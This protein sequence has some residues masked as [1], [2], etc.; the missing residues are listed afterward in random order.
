VSLELPHDDPWVRRGYGQGAIEPGERPAV[1][2]VDL[3][4]AFTDPAFPLG[5]AP[6]VERAV[7]G[8][9]RVVPAARA[10]GVPVY[11]TVVAWREDG[12]DIG[13]WPVKLPILREVTLDSRWAQVDGRVW[14]DSDVLLVKRQPRS[15]ASPPTARSRPRQSLRCGAPMTLLALHGA[16]GK[17]EGHEANLRDV[18]RRYAEVTS[19]EEVVAYLERVPAEVAG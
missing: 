15:P 10:T 8:T 19:G 18:H 2:V 6:L 11:Q 17:R 16:A 13:L 4:Y 12:S 7:A 14:D 3:Q 9:A 1:L 5:G